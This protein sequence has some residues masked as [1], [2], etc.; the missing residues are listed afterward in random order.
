MSTESKLLE[1]YEFL[2]D[3]NL[4]DRDIL[5]K[6]NSLNGPDFKVDWQ[7][8]G[9]IIGEGEDL[10]NFQLIQK[11][12]S[13]DKI[14]AEI[15][16]NGMTDAHLR[17]V[18]E[19]DYNNDPKYDSY[20]QSEAICEWFH[21]LGIRP[22]GLG[23]MTVGDRKKLATDIG[24]VVIRA[25][26][27]KYDD[28]GVRSL[29]SEKG[30]YDFRD[31]GIG[32]LP[33]DF[34]KSI[35]SLLRKNSRE[36]AYLTG[37]YGFG[38]SSSH[39]AGFCDMTVG[40]SNRYDSDRVGYSVVIKRNIN[41]KEKTGG[42][43]YYLIINGKIPEVK[44]S[45]FHHGTLKRHINANVENFG[46][47]MARIAEPYTLF[48]KLFP[49]LALPFIV[50]REYNKNKEDDKVVVWGLYDKLLSKNTSVVDPNIEINELDMD[51]SNPI[52]YQESQE[53]DVVVD[54]NTYHMGCHWFLLPMIH[55]TTQ[56]GR[57]KLRTDQQ[58]AYLDADFPII[59]FENGQG[60]AELSRTSFDLDEIKYL[61]NNLI[62]FIQADSVPYDI[63]LK[64]FNPN[65]EV[66]VKKYEKAIR[67]AMQKELC[68][69]PIL[70]QF[71][72]LFAREKIGNIV[73][74]EFSM[75]DPSLAALLTGSIGIGV[76]ATG[77]KETTDKTA[78]V[79]CGGPI[80]TEDCE[81]EG[82]GGPERPGQTV[83]IDPLTDMV[84]EEPPTIFEFGRNDDT[85]IMVR[86]GH[87][88]TVRAITNA[89][90]Y[91]M[92]SKHPEN[93]RISVSVSAI[94]NDNNDMEG[95]NNE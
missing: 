38:G 17:L 54:G 80:E 36:K 10:G 93:S 89:K 83:E 6:I 64:I 78:D 11:Q 49:K 9:F 32:I 71:N 58:R 31:Y 39:D 55:K 94:T 73:D 46:K 72:T 15:I 5:N 25:N 59:I 84:T 48:A 7:L 56:K 88:T 34:P 26:G 16:S 81:E 75:C 8:F 43:Y 82:T 65:R 27:Y 44:D 86:P 20:T 60:R 12:N 63:R 95:D 41:I 13:G 24:E 51:N 90:K 50:Y 14:M 37:A 61:Q 57:V 66:A 40:V 4:S 74:D 1:L 85:V 47:A 3:E 18:H 22:R 79:I 42:D 29:D 21:D 52:A 70:E 53:I 68:N 87:S 2:K 33:D 92:D 67:Q 28:D 62:V 91:Y 23:A 45:E 77:T 69:D 76:G 35:F 19:R 30:T